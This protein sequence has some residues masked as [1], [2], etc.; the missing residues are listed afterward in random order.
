MQENAFEISTYKK[1]SMQYNFSF[2]YNIYL[3]NFMTMYVC[4]CECVFVCVYWV[5][6]TFSSAKCKDKLVESSGS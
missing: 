4:V 6:A 1:E 5:N 2:Y 3:C